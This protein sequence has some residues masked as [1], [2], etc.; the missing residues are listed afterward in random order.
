[1]IHS[2]QQTNLIEP[3]LSCALI[4]NTETVES[5]ERTNLKLNQNWKQINSP[6]TPFAL[7]RELWRRSPVL[8][9][10]GAFHFALMFL[11]IELL[12]VDSRETLGINAWIKPMK[13]MAS[14]TIYLWTIAWLIAYI[15]RS[16]V[17]VR[18]I[19]WGISIAMIIETVCLFIQ[20]SRGVRSHFNHDTPFDSA[21]FG[22]M[23]IGIIIDS[24]LMIW[25][26]ILFFRNHATL[27]RTYLL[28]I[29]L[30]IILFLVG[31]VIGGGMSANGGHTIG[32]VDGGPGLPFVNWSLD[33]GDLRIAHA[34]GLH[35]L[36]IMPLLGYLLSRRMDRA[37]ASAATAVILIAFTVLYS[38]LM[39]GTLLQAMAGIP[40]V[41]L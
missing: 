35:G 12:L 16:R 40:V 8:A 4:G 11:T 39:L 36:Q 6:P 7:W 10:T 3:R 9:F 26:L 5:G 23:G 14:L 34:V 22:V 18:T 28:G 32:G 41:S 21:I 30:G 1:M 13:F 33:A 17:A 19:S 27:P 31:S 15:E 20:A 38:L 25:M 37:G 24:L 29:R 2:K